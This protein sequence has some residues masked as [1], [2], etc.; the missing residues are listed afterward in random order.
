M[1]LN[2]SNVGI[3]FDLLLVLSLFLFFALVCLV[4]G[5]WHNEQIIFGIKGNVKDMM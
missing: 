4:V 5:F 1:S 2:V 3:I